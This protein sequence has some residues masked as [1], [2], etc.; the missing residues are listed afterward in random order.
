LAAL[1][2]E[3]RKRHGFSLP[4]ERVLVAL[5]E[6]FAQWTDE[7]RPGDEVVFLPPVAGG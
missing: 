5:N 6:E 1:Y 4:P 2:A 7:P 3:L